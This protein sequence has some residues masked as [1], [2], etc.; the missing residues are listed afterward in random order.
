MSKQEHFE[1][2]LE[3]VISAEYEEFLLES[4]Y[5][6]SDEIVESFCI[7]FTKGM[8]K[9]GKLIEQRDIVKGE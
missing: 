2:F 7:G 8:I 6:H 9:L 3:E 4:G 1:K 5:Q